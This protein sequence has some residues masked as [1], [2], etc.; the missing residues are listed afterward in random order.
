GLGLVPR[1]HSL[2]GTPHLPG[3]SKRGD[4]ALRTLQIHGARALIRMAATR[5][6]M[7]DSWLVKLCRRRH[8]NIAAAALAAKNARAAWAMLIRDQPYQ[9]GSVPVRSSVTHSHNPSL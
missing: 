9:A 6:A 5:P 4:T 7:A 1:Q 8:R 2:G 3:I